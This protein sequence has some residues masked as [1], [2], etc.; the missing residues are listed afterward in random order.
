MGLATIKTANVPGLEGVQSIRGQP[1]LLQY[2]QH[3]VAH[4]HRVKVGSNMGTLKRGIG[5][6][7]RK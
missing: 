7:I 4:V 3:Y 6:E 5:W 1:F 2:T